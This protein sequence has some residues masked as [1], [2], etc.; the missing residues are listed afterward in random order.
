MNVTVTASGSTTFLV[1]P[2]RSEQRRGVVAREFELPNSP[3]NHKQTSDPKAVRAWVVSQLPSYL[4]F[5]TP[6]AILKQQ[7]T[8]YG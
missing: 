6:K 4:Q 7:I 8:V 5:S 3:A 2:F 1:S